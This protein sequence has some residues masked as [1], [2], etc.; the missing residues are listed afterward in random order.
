M[1]HRNVIKASSP[2]WIYSTALENCES[3][4]LCFQGGLKSSSPEA[5]TAYVL[6]SLLESGDQSDVS[7]VDIKWNQFWTQSHKIFGYEIQYL[8]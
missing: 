8:Y 3:H 7:I 5:L 4:L 1:S 2:A 6:V